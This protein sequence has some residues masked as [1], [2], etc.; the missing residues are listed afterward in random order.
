MSVSVII[1]T[2]CEL[3]RKESLW[4]AINSIVQQ[5][6][7]DI[8]VIVV[9]NGKRF[10]PELFAQLKADARLKV[11]YQEEGSLPAALRLGRTLVTR[12]FFSF[13][14]DDDEYYPGALRIRLAP[15]LRN[16]SVDL[17]VTNGYAMERGMRQLRVRHPHAINREPLVALI[18]ENWLASCGG[19]FRSATITLDYFDGHTKYF[20]WTLLGFRLALA[21]RKI[22]FLD[23]PTYCIHETPQS[24]SKSRGY[25]QSL[26]GFLHFLM[27]LDSSPHVLK[28]IKPKLAAAWHGASDDYLKAGEKTQAWR[29]HIK[30]LCYPSGWKY[31]GY[32]LRLC[33]HRRSRT[34]QHP[35]D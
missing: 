28:A 17:V 33:W 10:D 20:E 34:K 30:S 25:H 21:Q 12:V 22:L 23:E 26:I 16:S 32:S 27:T 1:P 15:M 8:E 18:K 35:Y 14:D 31:L 4:H 9:V 19:L 6:I 24:L 5:D 7:G 3:R 29:C 11:Y 2:T 13:L